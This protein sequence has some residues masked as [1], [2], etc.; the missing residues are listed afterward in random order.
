MCASLDTRCNS[1]TVINRTARAANSSLYSWG[2][3]GLLNADVALDR[4]D[5]NYMS[6]SDHEFDNEALPPPMQEDAGNT[7]ADRNM[8]PG[9][10]EKNDFR[11]RAAAI[12]KEYYL[13]GSVDE[14]AIA[15]T[16][17]DSMV[18]N[19]IF[20]KKAIVTSLFS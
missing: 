12:V 1:H 6:E 5:P 4:N 10:E 8:Y 3:R 14:V 17:I 9:E 2:S 16:D 7:A 18:M 15:L 13:S 20:V 19:Y 11:L